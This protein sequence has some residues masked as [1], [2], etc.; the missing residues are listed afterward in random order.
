MDDPE[1][2]SVT[3]KTALNVSESQYQLTDQ[4]VVY[5]VYIWV[6]CQTILVNTVSITAHTM[7]H[8]AKFK[9]SCYFVYGYVSISCAEF[10]LYSDTSCVIVVG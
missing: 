1:Q 7:T 5:R 9:D 10:I 4:A 8:S 2:G 3:Y 6:I